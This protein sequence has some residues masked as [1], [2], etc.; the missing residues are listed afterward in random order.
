MK[1]IIPFFIGKGLTSKQ[2][3]YIHILFKGKNL[4][5][6]CPE[7]STSHNAIQIDS[8]NLLKSKVPIATLCV[9]L[10]VHSTV[11]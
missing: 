6:L 8:G 5:G 2:L 9:L 11:S 3:N 7:K 10:N 4:A 1:G